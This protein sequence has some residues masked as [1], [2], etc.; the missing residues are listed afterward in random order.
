MTNQET[1]ILSPTIHYVHGVDIAPFPC[2]LGK[3]N[4]PG[5][6]AGTFAVVCSSQHVA[7]AAV[8]APTGSEEEL[9]LTHDG[10]LLF[11]LVWT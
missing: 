3:S 4:A 11:V 8:P 5:S 2:H 9:K 10:F 1:F 7:L 6:V